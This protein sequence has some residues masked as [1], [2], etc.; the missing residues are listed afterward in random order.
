MSFTVLFPAAAALQDARVSAV[1]AILYSVIALSAAIM[2]FTGIR[3]NRTMLTLLLASAAAIPLLR[4]IHLAGAVLTGL[5]QYVLFFTLFFVLGLLL[6]S[7]IVHLVSTGTTHSDASS[8]SWRHLAASAGLS[9]VCSWALWKLSLRADLC[10]GV[11]LVLLI[12]SRMTRMYL[13][14]HRILHH[15]YAEIQKPVPARSVRRSVMILS[16][17]VSLLYLFWRILFTLPSGRGLLT[18]VCAVLLL[19]CE[20]MDIADSL[21][22][23]RII[24][25]RGS[26]PLPDTDP[27]AVWPDVDV[28]IATYNESRQLLYK[29]VRGCLNMACP[30]PKR[31]HIY[32]CDDGQRP[33][34][35]DLAEK[36]HVGYLTRADRTGAKAGNLN[37]ALKH[38]TSPLVVTFDADMIPR[39]DFLTQ[40]I[41]YFLHA[42]K[43]NAGLP[44]KEQIPLGFVQTPQ[45]FYN[46]DL[47]QHH[48]YR[49][50]VTGNEQDYFFKEIQP[51]KTASNSVIYAGSNT[52]IS[53]EALETVGGFFT[54]AITEDFAT[55]LLIEG[56]GYVSL[57]LPTPLAF[58]LSPEDLPS[59]IQQR[60]RWGRGVINVLYQ[61]NI[62]FTNRFSV[63][64]KISYGTA[65]FFWVRSCIRMVYLIIPILAAFFHIPF[66]DST[67][68]P[69]LCFWVPYLLMQYI[70]ELAMTDSRRSTPWTNI[71]ETI[72]CP[73]LAGPI[74]QELLGISLKTFKVTDK[75]RDRGT[76]FAWRYVLPF[77]VLTIL[78]AAALLTGILNL[79]QGGRSGG[80]VTVFWLA[81]NLVLLCICLLFMIGRRTETLVGLRKSVISCDLL[82]ADS[83]QMQTGVAVGLS[84]QE[85]DIVLHG[86][87][88]LPKP[89][90]SCEIRLDA[91]HWT[92]VVQAVCTGS[93]MQKGLQV[94]RFAIEH[95]PDA[96]QF[97]SILYDRDLAYESRHRQLFLSPALFHTL[98][99]WHQDHPAG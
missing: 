45:A 99:H 25:Q 65:I 56:S 26:Y 28:F 71:Y 90:D 83:R 88:E 22:N 31:V 54:R 94:M 55:G 69:M 14:R 36:L 17:Y 63:A 33:E 62:F 20:A 59:L 58:G 34:I 16:A 10:A 7:L 42:W 77:L 98:K 23:N 84:E 32:L 49:E 92:A 80:I 96:D 64:Q 53:R 13:V 1:F 93:K 5:G 67:I 11:F 75:N 72:L 81:Y 78:D 44:E 4:L 41:P 95:V 76:H 27:D 52:V 37:N 50:W 6:H 46:E 47:F 30:D 85:L 39:R 68:G 3:Q 82:A 87:A 48:L 79:V 38:T 70:F 18:S 43:R 2:C 40:T 73:F 24:S 61:I 29:T 21:L 60:I 97:L 91:D 74:L 66:V 9:A 12:A 8:R 86:T 19:S 51:A 35:R 15:T 57:A 89:G